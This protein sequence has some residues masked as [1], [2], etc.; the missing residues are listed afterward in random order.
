MVADD[1]HFLRLSTIEQASPECQYVV[2]KP[3]TLSPR[4]KRNPDIKQRRGQSSYEQLGKHEGKYL[5]TC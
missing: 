1:S 4:L 3:L 2:N 5:E